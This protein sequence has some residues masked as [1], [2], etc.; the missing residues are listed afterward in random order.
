ML[1]HKTRPIAF[2]LSV[3]DLEVK[4]MGKQHAY[5]L[6]NALLRSYELT[7]DWKG[8][9]YSDMKLQWFYKKQDM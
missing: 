9:V 2:S 3:D 4:N 6:Q 7:T 5:Q 1:L 8:K